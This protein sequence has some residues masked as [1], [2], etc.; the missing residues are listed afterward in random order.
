MTPQGSSANLLFVDSGFLS[1]SELYRLGAIST[2]FCLV[3]YVAVGLPWLRFVA[4]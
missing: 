4:W 3:V 2:G 1:Q